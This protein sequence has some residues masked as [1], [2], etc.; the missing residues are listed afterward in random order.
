M[1]AVIHVADHMTLN[2][3]FNTTQNLSVFV[4]AH[5]LSISS[6][7]PSYEADL[8]SLTPI[9]FHITTAQAITHPKLFRPLAMRGTSPTANRCDHA[10]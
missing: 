10:P 2:P 6:D 3:K 5:P 4:R 8:Q 7:V 9:H 1:V